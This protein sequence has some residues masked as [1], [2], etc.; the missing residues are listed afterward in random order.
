ME[1]PREEITDVVRGLVTKPSL[2]QQAEVI[3]RYFTEDCSFSHFLLE[4]RESREDLTAIYQFH[5]KR[6]SVKSIHDLVPRSITM[7][8]PRED[9]KGV[10]SALVTKPSLRKQAEVIHRYFTEDCT[11]CHYILELGHGRKDL[12]AIYQLGELMVNYQG[13]DFHSVTYDEDKLEAA[14]QMTVHVK[15][16]FRLFFAGKLEF[17]VLLKLREVDAEH[18]TLTAN[19]TSSSRRAA[20]KKLY[21]I[22][23]QYDYFLRSHTLRYALGTMQAYSFRMLRN[24]VMRFCP[25]Q[26]TEATQGLAGAWRE[27]VE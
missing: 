10:V 21:Q 6:N 7:E 4:L 19:G 18:E 5:F 1:N 25:A 12:T 27:H 23:E 11:F 13:V 3:H 2:K 20:G 17:L 24:V 16:W 9:L 14:L 15:P 26:M 22:A 8:N